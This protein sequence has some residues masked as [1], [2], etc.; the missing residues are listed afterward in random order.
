MRTALIPLLLLS[1]PALAQQAPVSEGPITCT[2]PV[3]VTDTAR[4]LKQRY[5]KDAVVQDLP[6]AEGETN[7][8]IVLFPKAPDRRIEVA[9]VD[10][11][12]NRVSGLTLRDAK[13]SR[14]TI[15]GVTLG[16][17]LAD[18]QKVNGKPFI[19]SG[20]E[21]DYGGYADWKGGALAKPMA[22]GCNVIVRFGKDASAPKSLSGD[23]VKV[24]S[25]N[26]ALVKFA[27]V[28]TEIGF[29]FPEK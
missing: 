16:A 10:D 20:F 17:S 25:D 8:G 29:G 15:A 4:G 19:V 3:A 7:K 21:W 11:K 18:V 22:G 9:F 26:A 1:S 2:A 12:M 6:G 24:A 23:G 27:P 13:T 28:V 14:W 5:G